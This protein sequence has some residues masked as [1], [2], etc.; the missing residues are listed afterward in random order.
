VYQGGGPESFTGEGFDYMTLGNPIDY[1]PER[2]YRPNQGRWLTPD[3][4]GTDAAD[5]VNPQSWNRY[6]Y[7][8]NDPLRNVDPDGLFCVWDDGS[9]DSADDGDSG[10]S[11]NCSG[12]GGTWFNG[13]PSQWDPNAGDW[14][15]QKSGEFAG[16][17]QGINP[18]GAG[19]F[20]DPSGTAD[21]MVT[22]PF[23]FVSLVGSSVASE[24]ASANSQQGCSCFKTTAFANALDSNALP[25][26]S[27]QCAQYV[28]MALEAAGVNT[29]GHP[30]AASNYGPFLRSK[31]FSSVNQNGYSTA[32]GDI[33]VFGRTAQ[34]KDG[35]I[36]GYDGSQW[37]S[38]FRQNSMNP[39]RKPSSAGS[40]A[41]YRNGCKC[42]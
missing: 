30:V 32:V 9:F 25:R 8:M 24:V 27:G 41:I 12:L 22:A 23:S 26:S 7:V 4:A 36:A 42:D 39:Y 11:S 19:A 17:A 16:W 35:H 40:A 29:A 38:D 31:G 14:S 1:F 21:A 34:H 2:R 18:N 15:G 37:V 10:S 3:P 33:V 13:L 5:P 6:A 28:R 20:G